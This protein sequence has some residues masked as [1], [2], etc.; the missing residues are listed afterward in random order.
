M[1]QKF[2]LLGFCHSVLN[3]RA[4]VAI[5]NSE[6]CYNPNPFNEEGIKYG[7]RHKWHHKGWCAGKVND[8]ILL[9]C[10]PW[11]VGKQGS[12]DRIYSLNGG[13]PSEKTWCSD[14]TQGS[15]QNDTGARVLRAG[16]DWSRW[17]LQCCNGIVCTLHPKKEEGKGHLRMF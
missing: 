1:L 6:P 17:N 5:W 3:K 4:N 13:S 11:S 8:D 10:L 2:S 9:P 16:G 14:E 12:R 15:G 7:T